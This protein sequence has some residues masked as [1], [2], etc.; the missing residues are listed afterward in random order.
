M[1]EI[2]FLLQRNRNQNSRSNLNNNVNS[3]D[4]VDE[5]PSSP[6]NR[7]NHKRV[8]FNVDSSQSFPSPS[9]CSTA[10]PSA[11]SNDNNNETIST[12]GEIDNM[13]SNNVSADDIG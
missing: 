4:S 1:H 13:F 2:H 6:D 5:Q 3:I 12:Q 10:H 8:R 9:S 7:S 11:K